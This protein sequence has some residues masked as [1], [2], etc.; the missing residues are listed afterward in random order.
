MNNISNW[1]QFLDRYYSGNV[2]HA[3]I[4]H[5]RA[6]R[7]AEVVEYAA[8]HSKFYGQHFS[9][10]HYRGLT[11]QDS[12]V[13]PCT[14]KE[15]LRLAMYDMLCGDVRASQYFYSTTG[16]T[17]VPTPCPRSALDVEVNNC[18]TYWALK[19]LLDAHFA[20]GYRPIIAT[21]APNELHSVNKTIAAAAARLGYCSLDVFPMSP[22]MG[23]ERC[24]KVLQELKAD[25][26]LCSPGLLMSIAELSEAYG[27]D[28]REDLNVK[29]LL[30]TG[31]ICSP[32]MK[33]QIE[34]AWGAAV[35]DFMY[36]SQE[37]MV[38]ATAL[39]SHR[40]SM[41]TP[42]YHFEVLPIDGVGAEKFNGQNGLGELCAT[43]LVP[44]M[45]PLIRYRTGDVVRVSSR[46][47]EGD[48]ITILGRVK[49]LV[50]LKGQ[51]YTPLELEQALLQ[52]DPEIFNY[53]L[54]IDSRDGADFVSVKVKPRDDVDHAALKALVLRNI[55]ASLG[56]AGAVEIH[57]VVDL[58]SATGGWVSWKAARIVDKRQAQAA[59]IE[60]ASAAHLS[61]AAR[62][63]I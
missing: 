16:T 24:L 49:D 42:C 44:G 58:Q 11:P 7:F 26:L 10:V 29:V 63:S 50:L 17:G 59:T 40:L 55:T 45:K 5:W 1:V 31:E 56:V 18:N 57:P 32:I 12:A 25:V 13:L 35:Y 52:G 14:T 34:T 22:V 21:F 23:F 62:A 48:V 51:M 8:S 28:V 36:G 9:G 20:P 6:E 3:A 60:T 53:Q 15:H 61:V 47:D 41:I 39:P 38:M 33:Q 30:C 37:A 54:E 2:S 43:S 4:Q 27:I 19:R 46:P